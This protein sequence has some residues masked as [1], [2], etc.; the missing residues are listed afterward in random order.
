M[1][2]EEWIFWLLVFALVHSYVIF[3]LGVRFLASLRRTEAPVPGDLPFVTVL[4]AAHNEE[5]VIREKLQSVLGSDYPPEKLRLRIGSDASIDRTNAILQEFALKDPRIL[6]T[7]FEK[8]TG[9]IRIINRLAMESEEGILVITDA[10]VLFEKNT[11]KEMLRH[12]TD[13]SIGLVDTNMLH[14]GVRKDGIAVQEQTYIQ[15]EVGTKNAEGKIWGCMMGP[16]GGCYS[17]RKELFRPVPENYLVDDFYI[18]M[19]ILRQGKRCINEISAQVYEDVS[20]DLKEEFR[21][22]IR[23]ATGNYQNLF[24]FFPMLF[25][26]NA[27][28]FCFFSH[29]V[30]RWIGPWIML[31]L[32]F[33]NLYFLKFFCPC[34]ILPYKYTLA[35]GL[36]LLSLPLLDLFLGAIGLHVKVL[37]YATHFFTMNL[38]LLIGSLRFLRGVRSSVWQ[39]TRRHQ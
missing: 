13:P 16:F 7:Y 1:T 38:A 9:K 30:L 15:T 3:P 27:I 8:R 14:L 29:K 28:S 12:Y 39:P 5:H 34:E 18:N 33:Q 10:N 22:K 20:H 24:A 19:N 32:L 25:R 36:G 21:R 37:R 4:I 17:L 23:I 11:L 6:C 35:T 26:F 2:W 31:I